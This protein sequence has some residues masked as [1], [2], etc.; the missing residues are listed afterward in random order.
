MYFEFFLLLKV[1]LDYGSNTTERI[2]TRI[3][4]PTRQRRLHYCIQYRSQRACL[5]QHSLF[6][7][8]V[9]TKQVITPV[10]VV[11]VP[12]VV[13]LKLKAE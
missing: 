10:K 12:N 2:R 3:R 13:K 8:N 11:T 4:R 6:G 5:P 7:L 9:I 1:R